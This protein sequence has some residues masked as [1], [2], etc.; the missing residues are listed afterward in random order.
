[1][2]VAGCGTGRN[3]LELA[4]TFRGAHVLGIDLS[5]A[6]LAAAKRH[7]P[8]ALSGAVEFAQADILALGS[9]DRSF[10]L[11]VVGGVLHHMAE[12]LAGW[13]ELLKL[14]RPNGLMLLG[15]YSA[16]ARR[17]IVAARAL[18]AQR[19]YRSTPEDIRRCR[20][21]LLNGSEKF[22]FMTI[23]DFFSLSECRDLLFHVHERQITIPEI[24]DFLAENDLK[25]IGFEFSPQGAHV[26]H[27]D[28][29]AR[30]GWPAGDLD[31]WDAY[32]RENP[33]MFAAMYK[34]WIQKN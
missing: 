19:G 4:Q 30:A 25:F 24:K 22:N 6:S 29:F 31:R 14:M 8:P 12:P 2:L 16:Y 20:Q 10:D 11:I 34:F 1:V 26:Y 32:E 17:E 33:D 7:T 15:L 5:L 28:V 3:A 21:D 13:R 9:I 18:I 27:H 23:S